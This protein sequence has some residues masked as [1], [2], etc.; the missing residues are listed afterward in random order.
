MEPDFLPYKEAL[1]FK[2]QWTY[3]NKNRIDHFKSD[4]R[5]SL[6]DLIDDRV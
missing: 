3:D 4:W 6:D 2:Q 5:P 1:K